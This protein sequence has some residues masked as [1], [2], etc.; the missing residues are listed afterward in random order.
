MLFY[1]WIRNGTIF[2]GV[3]GTPV[4]LHVI[5]V[6]SNDYTN[7]HRTVDLTTTPFGP[8]V[9]ED[10]GLSDSALVS[11]RSVCFLRRLDRSI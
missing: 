8:L 9:R 10:S 11:L 2:D 4:I 1:N 7:T 5:P 6:I 3:R